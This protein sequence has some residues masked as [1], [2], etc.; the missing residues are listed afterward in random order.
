MSIDLQLYEQKIYSQNGEDGVLI[1][2]LELCY[3]NDNKDGKFFVEFGVQNGME[4]NT[5]ILREKYNWKG[6]QMDG[7]FE[8]KQI[9]LHR[10]YI[11]KDNILFL[12]KKYNVPL[13]INCLSVD[14]DS[15]DF[16]CL[17]KILDV[18]V[19]DIIICEY[20]SSWLSCDDKII[21]YNENAS[22]DGSNYFGASLLSLNKLALKYGYSLVY[23]NNNGVNCFFV[24]NDIIT[25]HN[26]NFKDIRNIEKIYK[27][28]RYGQGPN[29]GHMQDRKNRPWID[30]DN[31]MMNL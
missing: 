14:I 24:N 6:L 13:H 1:K 22:W 31:A 7:G 26:L 2:L 9:N 25:K 5:R 10:E 19:C 20:N 12:F 23:C 28:A 29:G 17:K 8:N 30:F 4:C 21:I 15:N 16:Y 3:N 18:Y 27:P 11:T